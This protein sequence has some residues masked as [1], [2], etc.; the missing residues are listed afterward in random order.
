M[1]IAEAVAAWFGDPDHPALVDELAAAGVRLE[2]SDDE[3]PAARTARS[4]A[5]RS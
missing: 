4:P 3:R 2:L 5:R 1:V